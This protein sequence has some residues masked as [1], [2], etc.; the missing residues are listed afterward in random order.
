MAL[1][2]CCD[3]DKAQLFDT[4]KGHTLPRHGK[5][6]VEL[7]AAVRTMVKKCRGEEA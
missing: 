1:Y 5:V 7:G 2:N 4:G 6:L 3:E